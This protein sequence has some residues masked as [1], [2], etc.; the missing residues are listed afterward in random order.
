V[1]ELKEIIAVWAEGQGNGE[2][3]KK[4]NVTTFTTASDLA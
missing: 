1:V 4:K 2:E 3:T